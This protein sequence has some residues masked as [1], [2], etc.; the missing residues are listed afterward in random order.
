MRNLVSVL[1]LSAAIS[2][3]AAQSGGPGQN[4]SIA[5]EPQQITLFTVDSVSTDDA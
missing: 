5:A 4:A 2:A 1:L 3:G